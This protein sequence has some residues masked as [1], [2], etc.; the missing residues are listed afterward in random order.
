MPFVNAF[1]NAEHAPK[2]CDSLSGLSG[3]CG[4]R[5]S[6]YAYAALAELE[7]ALADLQCFDLGI[8]S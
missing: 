4:N 7:A 1:V 5:A 6:L 2:W 3:I 8:K